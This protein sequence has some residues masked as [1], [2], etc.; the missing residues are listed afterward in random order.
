MRGFVQLL[1]QL[2]SQARVANLVGLVCFCCIRSEHLH[3]R[4]GQHR[5]EGFLWF[6]L[7]LHV[8]LGAGEGF[9]SH[10]EQEMEG[11]TPAHQWQDS[12]GQFAD[13]C[14]PHCSDFYLRSSAG[15]NWTQA[16]GGW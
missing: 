4:V 5:E 9:L 13:T 6:Q 14:D 12:G 15:A 3:S 8:L 11:R 10:A 2:R 16:T 1:I 7:R